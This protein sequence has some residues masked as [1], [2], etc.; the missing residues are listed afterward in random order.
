[1]ADTKHVSRARAIYAK[2]VMELRHNIGEIFAYSER[3]GDR[4]PEQK[5]VALQKEMQQAVTAL[6]Q[7]ITQ[8]ALKARTTHGKGR[9]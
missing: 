4:E 8:L 9:A 7:A 3:T 2:R 5:I 6:D 1:M